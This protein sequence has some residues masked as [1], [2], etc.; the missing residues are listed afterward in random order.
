MI[1]TLLDFLGLGKVKL[2]IAIVVLV[3][4]AGL[5]G[6]VWWLYKDNKQLS[7]DVA[8]LEITNQTLMDELALKEIDIEAIKKANSKLRTIESKNREKIENLEIKLNSLKLG[9]SAI[10]KPSETEQAINKD[11]ADALRCLELATGALAIESD[12]LNSICPE[13]YQGELK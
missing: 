7:K 10:S 5:A 11:V 2:A 8:Q 6:T 3:V 12:V 1:G 13:Y 4:I 9:Q